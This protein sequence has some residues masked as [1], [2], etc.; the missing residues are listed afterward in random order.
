MPPNPNSKRTSLSSILLFISNYFKPHRAEAL[1]RIRINAFC[2]LLIFLLTALLPLPSLPTALRTVMTMHNVERWSSEWVH[3]W[4]CIFGKQ[5]PCRSLCMNEWVET[6]RDDLL[7]ST[8]VAAMSIF[9]FNVLEGLYAVKYPRAPLPPLASP[10]KAKGIYMSPP[11]PQR[12]FKSLSPK[13]RVPLLCRSHH[14]PNSSS[15]SYSS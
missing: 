15:F 10:S 14:P 9:G 12:P 2:F 5:I 7:G 11:A 4:V 8:E 13:V 1:L 6:D 3:E